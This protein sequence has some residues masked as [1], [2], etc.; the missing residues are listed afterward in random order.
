ASMAC[1]DG[2]A[3]GECSSK[4]PLHCNAGI[5][6]DDCGK[7]PCPTNQECR[8]GRCIEQAT[9]KNAPWVDSGTVRFNYPEKIQRGKKFSVSA[10]FTPARNVPA[11]AKYMAEFFLGGAK[12]E[13]LI[14]SPG[15]A[16]GERLTIQI[17]GI[18]VGPGQGAGQAD[19]NF[20]LFALN[21]DRELLAATEARIPVADKL[22]PLQKPVLL[23]A[24]AEGDDAVLSWLVVEGAAQYRI[25]KSSDA[26]PAFIQY[27]LNKTV[28]GAQNSA[29]VQAL[30]G[31]TYFFVI[32]AADAFGNESPFSEMKA[33]NIK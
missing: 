21:A 7:C 22:E 32:T 14:V 25:Y 19:S 6:A 29:V 1:V 23:S 20:S 33:V 3:L 31:G 13:S 27:R 5:L 10:G 9:A 16:A 2:T 26:N 11:G 30:A 8:E 17:D 4:R 28:E 12:F 18:I 24:L 15:S